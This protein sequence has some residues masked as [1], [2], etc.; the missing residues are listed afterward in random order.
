MRKMTPILYELLNNF[1]HD[2]LKIELGI[3]FKDLNYEEKYKIYGRFINEH[4][5]ILTDLAINKSNF[6]WQR[7]PREVLEYNIKNKQF[8]SI[9]EYMNNPNANIIKIS[10]D[11]WKKAE[12]YSRMFLHTIK[13]CCKPLLLDNKSIHDKFN[14]LYDAYNQG[15]LTNLNIKWKTLTQYYLVEFSKEPLQLKGTDNGN[16]FTRSKNILW[17][18]DE[19]IEIKKTYPQV[20]ST[21]INLV[22]KNNISAKDSLSYINILET[23][24]DN[25]QAAINSYNEQ[26]ARLNEQAAINS[27][28][29]QIASNSV[30]TV[31]Y[32]SKRAN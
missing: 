18:V 7:I 21:L 20:N 30:Q 8:L 19:S 10:P 29:E 14:F 9:Y 28:N 15:K 22:D 27:Y 26:I 3:Q 4:K 5:E 25:E 32:K 31:I 23:A 12:I 11:L 2:T 16:I 1:M 13:N 24:R 17:H 6:Y